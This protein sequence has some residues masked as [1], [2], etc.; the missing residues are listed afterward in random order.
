MYNSYIVDDG[1]NAYDHFI[2]T[3][4]SGGAECWLICSIVK[5]LLLN[6]VIKH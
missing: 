2:I 5:L 6:K 3:D 4:I 1:Q